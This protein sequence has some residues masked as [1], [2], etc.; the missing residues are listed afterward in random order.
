MSSDQHSRYAMP[1]FQVPVIDLFAGPGGLG[2]GFSALDG[3][4]FRI[5][6]S[7][8]M[9]KSAHMTLRLRAFT[10]Q[11]VAGSIPP[12]YYHYVRG[13]LPLDELSGAYPGEWEQAEREAW[14]AELGAEGHLQVRA[15]VDEA[16]GAERHGGD[17]VLLGGP[18]C[19]AYSLVG[20]SRMRP[21]QGP[22][23]ESDRRHFLYREYLKIMADHAPA[24]FVFEN[25]KGLLSST[26]GGTEVFGQIR[27]D[28][29]FPG[30]ALDDYRSRHQ[31][32][33]YA[34]FPLAI[35]G[36][37]D[38]REES[39]MSAT[40]FVVRT[41]QL[42]L[43]QARHR[44]I[45]VGI[46]KDRM[47]PS[48]NALKPLSVPDERATLREVLHELPALRSGLS[49]TKDSSRDWERAVRRSADALLKENQTLSAAMQGY[50]A[51]S[52]EHIRSPR[53]GRGGRFVEATG[54]VPWYEPSWYA[55]ANVGGVLNHE[56]R[57]HM[58]DDLTR[59]LFVSTFGLIEGR[60][61]TL[62]DFPAKL[63]PNHFNVRLAL[64]GSLFADRFRV[65]LFDR[66]SS[67]ITSHISKDGHYFIHPDP[68][69]CRSLTVRE[70]ARLQTF[71]DNYF[72]EGPRTKQY[73]QV[74]NAVPPLLAK[75]IAFVVAD[76]LGMDVS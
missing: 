71:P 59:Y 3:N 35:T 44:V 69:Q 62:A 30:K 5:A 40:R 60:S 29:R 26:R 4:L 45:I 46:R 67:T 32:V 47:A 57:G 15:R 70:A 28:L 24:A 34:L 61:P 48:M 36:S 50:I 8:E 25:V 74:G 66:P 51:R 7:I 33:E 10:R 64:R 31:N 76:A 2:E 54:V 37:K 16:L 11:F 17:A 22:E 52:G 73:V 56:S 13:E 42:G 9:E 41:E 1:A 38:D 6:I 23:F 20:R 18:P 63:L 68:M 72:F 53:S 21:V 58:A 27:E 55:D 39:D 14:H 43:P 49:R 12:E 19:Q 75:Q 65:Q